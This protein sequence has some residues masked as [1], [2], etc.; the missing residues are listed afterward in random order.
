MPNAVSFLAYEEL[1]RKGWFISQYTELARDLEVL[2]SY[3][4]LER[5]QRRRLLKLAQEIQGGDYA[6][7]GA[8]AGP[9]QG[10]SRPSFTKPAH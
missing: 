2:E 10:T 5:D 1:I 9:A 7:G 3:G 8:Q 6:D 4:H